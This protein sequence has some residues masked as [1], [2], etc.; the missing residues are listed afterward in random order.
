MNYVSSAKDKSISE[1]VPFSNSCSSLHKLISEI[2]FRLP[3]ASKR[4][5]VT[6]LRTEVK[7]HVRSYPEEKYATLSR[8]S[9]RR[10]PRSSSHNTK[11]KPLSHQN[12]PPTK[13]FH[14]PKFFHPL[15]PVTPPNMEK[16]KVQG[17]IA[18]ETGTF[19]NNIMARSFIWI[20]R[21]G[22]DETTQKPVRHSALSTK[23]GLHS[24]ALKIRGY[25]RRLPRGIE[26]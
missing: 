13:T 16:Q 3:P 11:R 2:N 19:W 24:S 10:F 14:P 9:G 4:N 8:L 22:W 12:F 7:M 6:A 23:Y 17:H 15:N 18:K 25:G 1:S 20:W 26:T 21:R 5:A